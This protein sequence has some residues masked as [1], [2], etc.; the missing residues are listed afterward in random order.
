MFSVKNKLVF[1]TG[2]SSGIGKACARAFAALGA[3][4]V[5]VARRFDRLQNLV[6]ELTTKFDIK[7][8]PIQMDIRD[9]DLVQKTINSLPH[10]FSRIDILVNNAGLSRGLGKI[11]DAEV[12]DWEE[13]IDTNIK[14]LL[15]V[16]RAILPG[17]VE[18][19]S[20]H[21]INIGSVSGREAYPG[22]ST[23]CATKAAVKLLTQGMRIDLL[24]KNIRVTNIEPGLVDSE[25]SLVRFRGNEDRAAKVYHGFEPL[26]A[27]D[28][29]DAVVYAATR[30]SHVNIAE[31][32]VLPTAQATTMLVHRDE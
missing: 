11:Y 28:I 9:W 6:H 29:A 32:L 17:M 3:N 31:M 1:I 24:G 27:E 13:M 5:L 22:G 15:Y 26:H 8:L 14:G 21:I 12:L 20:G 7:A 30:P 10:H 16:T 19:N 23:Y 18:R 25:F 4:M 2:T